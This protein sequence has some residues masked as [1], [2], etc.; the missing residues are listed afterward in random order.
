VELD[1]RPGEHVAALVAALAQAGGSAAGPIFAGVLAE[2]GPAPL[3]LPY[4]VVLALSAVG[5]V[6]VLR[7]PEPGLLTGGRWRIQRPHVPAPIRARFA[8]LSI[9]S[10]AVWGIC[11]LFLSVVPSYAA[12]LLDTGNLAL[13]GSVS[14]LVLVSSCAAQL[15]GRRVT[16]FARAQATGLVLAAAG[17]AAL[18]AAFPLHSLA[19][20]LA[21]AALAGAGHGIAFLAAQSEL[22]VA[23]PPGSRGEVNAAF[24]TGTYLGVAIGV[25][26][27]GLLTLAVPLST[28]VTAFAA[29]M[30]TVLLSTAAW[31]LKHVRHLEINVSDV[32]QDPERGQPLE[33]RRLKGSDPL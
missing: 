16:A 31:H 12:D 27:T 5:A 14:G 32:I 10:A 7:I 3:V 1:P 17:L 19:W 13:L 25:I 11:A 8:R 9:T 15:A 2:W 33:C 20:L 26:G 4:V 28:A 21:A 18:V 23:A 22:N 6:A 29:T 30:G 24:Y